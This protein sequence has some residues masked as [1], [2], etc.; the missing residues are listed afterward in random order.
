[1]FHCLVRRTDASGPHCA[2]FAHRTTMEQRKALG[3]QWLASAGC[4]VIY[5]GG[6]KYVEI[7]IEEN[8]E[9]IKVGCCHRVTSTL[10]AFLLRK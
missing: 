7:L 8:S 3:L 5:Y 2:C 4:I 1:M 10:S 9:V 6:T